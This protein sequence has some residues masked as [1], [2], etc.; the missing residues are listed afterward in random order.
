MQQAGEKPYKALGIDLVAA[1]ERGQEA[2]VD[3]F[4]RTK[5]RVFTQK[6]AGRDH[7]LTP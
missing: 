6:A 7:D 2:D 4:I 3:R 5:H 1:T